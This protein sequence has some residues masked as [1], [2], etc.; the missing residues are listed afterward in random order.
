MFIY[1]KSGIILM[2]CIINS[3]IDDA[4]PD[5]IVK[6]KFKIFT[7]IFPSHTSF[8]SSKF[9][10]IA[11][12]HVLL[13]LETFIFILPICSFPVTQRFLFICTC[14]KSVNLFIQIYFLSMNLFFIFSFSSSLFSCSF[15]AI[16]DPFLSFT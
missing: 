11:F 6:E 7:D 4:C 12:M 8:N 14:Y 5:A 3:F 15:L 16:F 1:G 13:L 10:L 2:F 9:F